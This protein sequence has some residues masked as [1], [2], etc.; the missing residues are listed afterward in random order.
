M[1]RSLVGKLN[2]ERLG[3]ALSIWRRRTPSEYQQNPLVMM[4]SRSKH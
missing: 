1:N 4:Q 3:P 2:A